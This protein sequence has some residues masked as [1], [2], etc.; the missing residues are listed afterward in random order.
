M[1]SVLEAFAYGNVDPNE[2]Y[3]EKD[4]KYGSILKT[5]SES[6]EK[7][8]CMLNDEQKELLLKYQMLNYKLTPLPT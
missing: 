5:I 1:K 8:L 3:F 7:L 2:G 6:E 4:S